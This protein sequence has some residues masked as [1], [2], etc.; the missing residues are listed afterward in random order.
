MAKTELVMFDFD[1]T[2]VDTAPDLVRATNRLLTQ[3]DLSPLPEAKIRAGI[4][5]GLKQL[6]FDV[7]PGRNLS[8]A[9]QQSLYDDFTK[10]YDE[11]F[12]VSPALFDGAL[13]FLV[14]FEGQIAIV[15][16]KRERFIHAIL[17]HLGIDTLPWIAVIGGD[18]FSTMK[19]H[20]QPFLKAMELAGVTPEQSVIV[21]DGIPDVL[22]AVG[23]N[24]PCVAVE[25]GY[26]TAEEL[27]S[28]GAWQTI[29]AYDELLPLLATLG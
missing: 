18:T 6:L 17:K 13:K 21:G 26:T 20:A 9:E 12:L 5:M 10:I 25:F 14:E 7:Y 16:N 11:E 22:G 15:S 4:G 24:F 27:M 29:A 3:K 2:L 19:P 28:L 23:L 8:P 1:G